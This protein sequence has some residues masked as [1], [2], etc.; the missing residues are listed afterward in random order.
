MDTRVGL[1]TGW[2]NGCS[3][4]AIS[5]TKSTW[6]LVTSGILQGSVLRP[7]LFNTSIKGLDE[8]MECTL[9]KFADHT[10]PGGV[11]DNT[12]W[13]CCSS[14]GPWQTRELDTEERSVRKNKSCFLRVKSRYQYTLGAEGL[15]N[16]LAEKRLRSWQTTNGTWASNVS[17]HQTRPMVS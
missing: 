11:V 17:L 4:V 3:G 15:E 14:E 8:G 10:E 7:I 5:S 12:I 9:S 16:R 6:G 1:K 13:L 2:R